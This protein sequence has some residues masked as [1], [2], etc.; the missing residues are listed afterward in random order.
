MDPQPWSDGDLGELERRLLEAAKR[1]CVPDALGA[2][3]A[4]GLGVHVA[5]ATTA[6]ASAA[7][8]QLGA[9]LF[10]KV[11]LWGVLS[12]A[13]VAA[14]AGWRAVQSAAPSAAA[15]AHATIPD[16]PALESAVA[17]SPAAGATEEAQRLSAA[18]ASNDRAQEHPAAAFDDAALRAEIALLDRA[19]D[20]LKDGASAR[21]LRLL[22]RHQDRFAPPRLAPEAAALRIEALVQSG[23]HAQAA[24]MT[25]QFISTYPTHPLTAHVSTL[26]SSPR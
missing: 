10:A 14:V 25:H 26:T 24:T 7:G 20:A 19:R 2:R 12:L 8:G 16:R 22:D 18:E 13:L 4:Q 21:A 9:P 17:S 6:A 15:A 23:A 3:M 1:D 5:S 11:G